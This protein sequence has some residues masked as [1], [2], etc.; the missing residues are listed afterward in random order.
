MVRFIFLSAWERHA[1]SLTRVRL[2]PLVRLCADMPLPFL[3]LYSRAGSTP[4]VPTPP[5]LPTTVL[6][7]IVRTNVSS[8]WPLGISDPVP[9]RPPLPSLPTDL[10]TGDQSLVVSILSAGTFFGAL[11]AYPLGDFLGR[12]LGLIA[13]CAVFCLGVSRVPFPLISRLLQP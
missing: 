11:L 9:V 12:R 1:T 7:A 13:S 5:L 6:L 8:P 2:L 3:L 10:P 4:S